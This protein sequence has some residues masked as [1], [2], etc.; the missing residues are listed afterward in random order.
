MHE[1]WDLDNA[2][3]RKCIMA[4]KGGN[5]SF[6]ACTLY[7]YYFSLEEIGPWPLYVKH[8]R[9]HLVYSNI[10][11]KYQTCENLDLVIEVAR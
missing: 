7:V 1:V 9:S 2:V 10:C 3:Y 11:V 4:L 5:S 6:D 8:Q